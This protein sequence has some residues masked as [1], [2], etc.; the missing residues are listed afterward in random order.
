MEL[1][2]VFSKLTIFRRGQ[3]RN[4]SVV[5]ETEPCQKVIEK[6]K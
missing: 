4:F 1:F 5:I 6:I 3:G 2:M